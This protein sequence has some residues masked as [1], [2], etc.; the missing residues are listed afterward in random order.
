M[1]VVVFVGLLVGA[2]EVTIPLDPACHVDPCEEGGTSA[3]LT[4]L[5]LTG[6][7]PRAL[8]SPTEARAEVQSVLRSTHARYETTTAGAGFFELDP[9]WLAVR[10]VARV[11]LELASSLPT[12]EAVTLCP[13]TLALARDTAL[14]GNMLALAQASELV[15][16]TLD[17]CGPIFDRLPPSSRPVAGR[18]LA[19]IRRTSISRFSGYSSACPS[20]R[21]RRKNR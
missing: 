5:P 3:A 12:D 20:S 13:D 16:R 14:I 10:H 6:R 7:D 2:L 4:G 11:G 17:A 1:R 15:A 9:A 18:T 8:P 19:R 21:A